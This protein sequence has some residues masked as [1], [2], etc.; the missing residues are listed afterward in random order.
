MDDDQ[1]KKPE[2]K[3]PFDLLL[4]VGDAPVNLGS[5]KVDENRDGFRLPFNGQVVLSNP[6]RNLM[7]KA[8]IRN[9]SPTGVG[10]E[11][12][13]FMIKIGDIFQLEFGGDGIGIRGVTCSVQ[14][15][16]EVEASAKKNKL[17]GLQFQNLSAD[18][19]LKVKKFFEKL[20]QEAYKFM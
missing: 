3:S 13:N 8:V 10:V 20:Q 5:L 6:T 17:V 7:T 11:T 19:K 2:E 16:A 14:W 4:D 9:I 12:P 18:N 1:G 15:V